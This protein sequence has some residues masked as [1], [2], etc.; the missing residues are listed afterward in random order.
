MKK[1]YKMFWGCV[2]P[3]QLPFVEKAARDVLNSFQVLYSD[4]EGTTCC[5]EKLIVADEDPFVHLVTAARNLALAEREGKELMV[6]CNGCYATL[7]TALETLRADKTLLA[8]VNERLATIGMEFKCRTNVHHLVGVIEEDIRVARVKKEAKRPL[9]GLRV[10]VH[11]GCNLLRPASALRMDDPLTPTVID[12]LV[13]ALGGVSVGYASKMACCGGNFSLTEGKAQSDAMLTRKIS[14][15]RAAGADVILVTCPSCFTQFDFR[16]ERLARETGKPEEAVPVLHLAELLALVLG[17]E[18]DE[19]T[20]KR[21]RIKIDGVL[22]RWAK[23]AEVQKTVAK[24]FDLKSLAR[25]ASCAACLKDCP[26]VLAYKDFNPNGIIKMVLDGELEQVLEKGDYW[27]CLDCLTCY[28]MCPQ[29]FGMRAVFSRLKEIAA[30]RGKVPEALGK[31][32]QAFREKGR[33]ADGSATQRKRLGL[34]DL[35]PGG[36]E[37]LKRLLWKDRK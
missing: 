16:Q 35:A 31:I 13:E 20:L 9:A 37:E 32:R 30:E 4:L 29:R 1:H 12:G 34:P 7:K 21:R 14:D 3:A 27:N 11:Y 24:E 15:I 26:V 17:M 10:A 2:I 33:V 23:L 36:E 6:V 19:S 18:P 28:E 8:R 25:C 22:A 5:P